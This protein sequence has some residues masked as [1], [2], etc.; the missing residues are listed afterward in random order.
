MAEALASDIAGGKGS[1]KREFARGG[2]IE[3]ARFQGAKRPKM[4]KTLVFALRPKGDGE[5]DFP[6]L[7]VTAPMSHRGA[8]GRKP[9]GERSDSSLAKMVVFYPCL[10]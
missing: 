4:A 10:L 1:G 2:S 6:P 8:R 5:K 7:G 9:Y 3:T